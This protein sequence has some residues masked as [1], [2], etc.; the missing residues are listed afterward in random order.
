VICDEKKSFLGNFQPVAKSIHQIPFNRL[1]FGKRTQ[2]VLP[3]AQFKVG[4]SGFCFVLLL[5]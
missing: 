4:I 5:R 1:A 3:N 2:T